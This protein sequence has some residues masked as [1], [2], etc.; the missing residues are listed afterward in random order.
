[1]DVVATMLESSSPAKQH[2]WIMTLIK[3]TL[4]SLQLLSSL[5][6]FSKKTT[7]DTLIA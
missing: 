2:I 1:M 5:I 7:A 4:K 3:I 6:Y